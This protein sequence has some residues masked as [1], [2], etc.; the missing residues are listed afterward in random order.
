MTTTTKLRSLIFSLLMTM[1]PIT[2]FAQ[3]RN[4]DFFRAGDEYN[5]NRLYTDDITGVIIG[6]MQNDNPTPLNSGLLILTAVGAGYAI[7]RRKRNIKNDATLLLTAMMLLGLT[8]CKKN[9]I[10]PSSDGDTV[11]MTLEASCGG[12][13]TVFDPSVPGIRWEAGATEFISVGSSVNGYL[14]E[15]S[16]KSQE[17]TSATN[18]LSFSGTITAPAGTPGEKLYFFYLGNGRHKGTTT[19]NFSNQETSAGANFVTDFVVAIGEGTVTNSGGYTYTATADLEVKTAIAYFNI[20]AFSTG[21]DDDYVYL[22]GNDVYSTATIDYREGTITGNSKGSINIGSAS[23]ANKY[24][25]L[26][27]SVSTET[28]LIFEGATKEGTFTLPRGIQANRYYSNGVN[29][30]EVTGKESYV[31]T[32][33]DYPAKKVRFSP[34]NLQYKTGTGWRFAEHQYE[35]SN[36]TWNASDWVDL[37]G[38]GTWSGTSEHWDPTNTSPYSYYSWEGNYDDVY[39]HGT[40]TNHTATNWFTL[41]RDQW[42]YL[43]GH[44]RHGLATIT[45][46]ENAIHGM[47]ILPDNSTLS[48]NTDGSSWSDNEYSESQWFTNMEAKGAVFL[49]AAGYRNGTN[50]NDYGNDYY[51]WSCTEEGSSAWHLS[52]NEYGTHPERYWG[53][54]V[55]LVR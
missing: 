52:S 41:S 39:F 4:D 17:S 18:R 16:G 31:F 28:T 21:S 8:Q 2:S 37:F 11:F 42:Q 45:V 38:W 32:V 44:S 50:V 25:A 23:E 27:P 54:G 20:S 10:A 5:D 29:A 55:R 46:G 9:N 6:V 1:L 12:G 15:L 34:G 53:L 3:Q 13:R 40:L 48:I 26:I 47:V 22:R 14:G 43:I 35:T 36:G 49:P 51:Y 24:V 33:S 7:T 19:L 30:L